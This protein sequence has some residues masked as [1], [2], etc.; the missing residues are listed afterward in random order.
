MNDRIIIEKI[1]QG[2]QNAFESLIDKYNRYVAVIVLK[3]LGGIVEKEDIQ[4]VI[5]DTF[6]LLWKNID[7]IDMDT[8]ADLKNY[9]ASIAINAAKSKLHSYK[10]TLPLTDEIWDNEDNEIEKFLTKEWVISCIR[11]LKRSEQRV[12]IKYY[13]QC[14]SIKEIAEEEKIPE[15]TVKTHMRRGKTH[16]RELLKKGESL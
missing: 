9:L 12:L 11:H 1:R 4:D 8:Y 13:Y 3:I 16:L 10:Q 2:N 6:F 14:K 15:S 5:N 7:K